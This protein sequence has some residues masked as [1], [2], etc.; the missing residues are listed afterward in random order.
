M[1][2]FFSSEQQFKNIPKLPG[3][4]LMYDNTGKIVYIGKAK[5]L[6]SR[7]KSYFV[8]NVDYRLISIMFHNITNIDYIVCGSEKEALLLEQRLINKLQPQY[9]IIWR[10]DKSYLMIEL[11]LEDPFPRLNFVRYKQYL[12]SP[13]EK[14]KLYFGPYP[15]ARQIKS[16]IKMVTKF[17]KIRKCKYDSK[18]FFLPE[19]KS[20]FFSCIYY[21]TNQCIAPC[22]YASDKQ[23]CNE[24]SQVYKDTVK[25]VILF[26]RGK[27]KKLLDTLQQQLTHYAEMQEFEKAI[28]LRDTIKFISNIF[29]KCIIKQI[30]EKDVTE[31]ALTQIELLKKIQQKFLLKT[32][33]VVIEA[34]DVSTFHGVGSCGSIVRF[35]NGVPDKNNYR[36]YKIK[37]LKEHQ[38]DDYSMMKEIVQRRYKRL[39]DEKKQLPNLLIIDGGKGQLNVVYKVLC[40][41]SLEDKIELLSIAKQ[42]DT[43]YSLSL[44]QGIKLSTS[45]ED[46]LIRYIRDEA[47][48]FA[49]KYHRLL[50]KK[51]LKKDSLDI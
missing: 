9:N 4:Y 40:E 13:K 34:V 12:S 15:S 32:L 17:F 46:N 37:T 23:K 49:I 44:P 30:D 25:N 51:K 20:K 36:R 7:I 38:L 2:T 22:I 29:S 28:V 35:L 48:R 31:T 19:K 50:I 1:T 42:E 14:N 45:K 24:I 11:D 3:V 8:K 21:Q 18:L 41:F 33:P 39:L 43:V 27:N 26:L 5:N 47:H 16:V 10:D 6:Y